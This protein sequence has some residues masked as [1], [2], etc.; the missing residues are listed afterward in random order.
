MQDVAWLSKKLIAEKFDFATKSI[1]KPYLAQYAQR[2]SKH[3]RSLSQIGLARQANILFRTAHHTGESY[4]WYIPSNMIAQMDSVAQ[5][6]VGHLQQGEGKSKPWFGGSSWARDV[7]E[8]KQK[9]LSERLRLDYSGSAMLGQTR[10][11]GETRFAC[12][13]DRA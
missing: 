9:G 6:V 10:H 7:K 8:A 2:L 13:Y 12:F 3:L 4:Q 1:P 5:E 11:L